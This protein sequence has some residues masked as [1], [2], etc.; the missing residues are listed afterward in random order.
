M[1]QTPPTP[2]LD[3]GNQIL[4]NPLRFDLKE[5]QEPFP[6]IQLQHIF[7]NE[8]KSLSVCV[9]FKHCNAMN[10]R[11]IFLDIEVISTRKPH[12]NSTLQLLSCLPLSCF[13]GCVNKQSKPPSAQ[14]KAARARLK[15]N[16]SLG[17]ERN[18]S[19]SFSSKPK[20]H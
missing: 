20:R 9:L 1:Y 11:G 10:Q 3:K 16:D 13:Y 12:R 2:Q 6:R 17:M 5:L 19:L 7:I 18:E 14:R 8:S 4:L 15:T